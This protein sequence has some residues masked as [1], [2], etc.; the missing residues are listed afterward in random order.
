[1]FGVDVYSESSDSI[2]RDD[3]AQV[4][5][6]KATEG[7]TYVNPKAN[8]QYELAKSLGKL[9]GTY[10]YAS[11]G[12]PRKEAQFFLNNVRNWIGEAV[13]AIDWEEYH[14]SAFGRTDWVRAFVDEVHAQTG[15]WPLVY[16]S[17]SAIPQVANTV[18]DCGLWVAKY[19]SMNW[20]SWT[21]PNMKVNTSPWGAYTIWQ[22]TGGDMDRD[23]LNIDA[24][25]WKKLAS[26]NGVNTQPE[27][28][29]QAVQPAHQPKSFVDDLGVKWYLENGTF[30]ITED[31]GI[32]LR[33]GATTKSSK[34]GVLPKGSVV[35]YDAFCHSGDYVWIRQP[36]GNGQYG[37]LPTGEDRNGTRLNYWGKFE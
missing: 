36:R 17:E 22:Y 9:V 15:V 19:P 21:V 30:T 32:V 7:E 34:I 24:N 33:W 18:N 35:K 1:M 14:N 8:H 5:I 16:V 6:V 28:P 27:V 2:I 25:G 4:V 29:K 13:L 37:Y 20:N 3:H 10:H 11:G 12:D 26:P 23:L 31:V